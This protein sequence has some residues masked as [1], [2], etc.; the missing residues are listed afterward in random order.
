M[1][2]RRTQEM[3]ALEMIPTASTSKLTMMNA[4]RELEALVQGNGVG[5]IRKHRE[6]K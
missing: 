4:L 2:K 5:L 3:A 6:R 1:E